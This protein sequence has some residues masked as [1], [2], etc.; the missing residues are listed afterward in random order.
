MKNISQGWKYFLLFAAIGLLTVL[1]VGFNSRMTELRRLTAEEERVSAHLSEL[2]QTKSALDNQIAYATSEVPVEE[3]AREDAHKKQEGDIPI[4]LIPD[5]TTTPEAE[6][7]VVD[8]QTDVKNWQVWYA[9]F[10]E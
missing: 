8:V 1:V 10:F 9:L 5:E 2:E 4:V 3:W 6:A 7:S